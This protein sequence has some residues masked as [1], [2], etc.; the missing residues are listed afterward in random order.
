MVDVEIESGK[1]YYVRMDPRMGFTD[2]RVT[3]KSVTEAEGS[4]SIKKSKQRTSSYKP[5]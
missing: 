5:E 3:L 2:G 1:S 4:K